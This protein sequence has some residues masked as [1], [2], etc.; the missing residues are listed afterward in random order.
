MNK[1]D[2]VGPMEAFKG[3]LSKNVTFKPVKLGNFDKVR[4][5]KVIDFWLV[6]L[7]DYLHVAKVG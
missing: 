1:P 6:E 5:Q 4:D 7:E 3:G 2:F